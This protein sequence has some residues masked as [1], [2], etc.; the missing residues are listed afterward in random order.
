MLRSTF[1]AL[2]AP[3]LALVTGCSV[4]QGTG[5]VKS[6]ALFVRDCWGTPPT[7]AA[8]MQADGAPYD[9][10]PDFF[11]ANPYRSTLQIRVQ[12]GSDLTQFS[13]GLEVL[14]DDISTIRDA[15]STGVVTS[16]GVPDGGTS[17]GGASDAGADGGTADPPTP[18]KATFRVGL[19]AGIHPPGS[20]TQP[21]PDIVA[22]PPIVHVSLYLERSCHAQNIVLYAVDG[23]VTFNALF[24]GDPN[25]TSADAK[26]TDATF[27]VQVGDL[28]D[29]PYGEYAAD[30]PAGLQSRLTGNFR[31]YY[32]RGQPAQP[33]P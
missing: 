12:R 18:G 23:T 31:F 22:D 7:A 8:P 27:D 2:V 33:F 24:D 29:V 21:P 26:L 15:I 4:G 5:E 10:Q 3:L 11:A 9:L 13:D 17:D 20:S 14:I 16:G 32:E 1:P 6:D 28:N 30:V 25:E 19:P